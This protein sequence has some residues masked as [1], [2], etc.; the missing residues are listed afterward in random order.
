MESFQSTMP[1]KED[2]TTVDGRGPKILFWYSYKS[3]VLHLVSDKKSMSNTRSSKDE[4]QLVPGCFLCNLTAETN[5]HLFLHWNVFLNITIMNWTMQEHTSDLLSCWIRR[6]GSKS[7][8]RLWKLNYHVY[9]GQSGERE[10]KDV[11][12]IGPIPSTKLNGIVICK[13]SLLWC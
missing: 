13:V 1:T 7:Q 3:E 10:M 2:W 9:G 4:R 11:L 5:N 12:K 6:G 8:K